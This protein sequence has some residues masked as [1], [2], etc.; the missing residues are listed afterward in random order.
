MVLESG[1]FDR[2]AFAGED[3]LDDGLA[4]HADQIA[5]DV[6]ELEEVCRDWRLFSSVL[7]TFLN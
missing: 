5:D 1:E 7:V 2:S 6:L 4:G 3:G